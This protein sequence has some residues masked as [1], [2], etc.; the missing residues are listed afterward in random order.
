MQPEA[1]YTMPPN[2][3]QLGGNQTPS[4][5]YSFLNEQPKKPSLF[6]SFANSFLGKIVFIIILAFLIVIILIVIKNIVSP[7]QINKSSY[8]VLVERQT[9]MLHILNTDVTQTAITQLSQSDQN[10]ST[11]ANLALTTAQA[12]TLTFLADYNDKITS[13]QLANIYNTAIDQNLTSAVTSN[14]FD[15]TFKSVMQQQLTN[16]VSELKTAYSGSRSVSG[17]SLI[18]SEYDEAQQLETALNSANS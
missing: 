5:D 13:K 17:K 8:L 10:F 12:K 6:P 3:G 9:E 15:S 16:Y 4:P 1:P 14:S 7:S 18:K 11:T 2:P